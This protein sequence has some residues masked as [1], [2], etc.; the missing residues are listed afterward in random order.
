MKHFI[1]FILFINCLFTQDEK[2]KISILD[3]DG[4]GIKKTSV[5]ASFQSLETSLIESNQFIVIEK[6]K[7]D[8]ILKEQK[9]QTTSGCFTDACAVEVGQLIGADYLVST[10][11]INL[12][13]E[14]Y[15][16]NVKIF[17]IFQG[18][19]SEKV[20]MEVDPKI[21]ALLAGMK[22]ASREIV[23]R[24][25][26]G[27]APVNTYGQQPGAQVPTQAKAYGNLDI[28]T[29][30][31]GADIIIDGVS[32]GNTPELIKKLSAENHTLLL[33]YPNYE[34]LKKIVSIKAD[35]TITVNEILAPKT[36]DIEIYS[37]P[38]GATIEFRGEYHLETPKTIKGI[39]T[40]DYD[41]ILTADDYKKHKQS[42]TIM[43]NETIKMD[44]ELLPLPAK[45][46]I[47]GDKK[48][49]VKVQV[50]GR[51]YN[52]DGFVNIE[53]PA[54]KQ[55]LEFSRKGYRGYSVDLN[56]PPN[57]SEDVEVKLNKFKSK[58]IKRDGDNV[59]PYLVGIGASW[60][61]PAQLNYNL[62]IANTKYNPDGSSRYT[63]NFEYA[64]DFYSF[65]SDSLSESEGVI[66]GKQFAIGVGSPEGSFNYIWGHTEFYG[67]EA[68]PV[69]Y[70]ANNNIYEYKGV[71]LK[72]YMDYFFGE[73]GATWGDEQF[74]GGEAQFY[75]QLGSM[76]NLKF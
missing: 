29:E 26:R 61:L 33:I 21:T 60:G 40:G 22:D 9:D 2:L 1:I 17:D 31:A 30:P 39:I 23:R 7:R 47:I 71:T 28:S 8:E 12:D 65:S 42:I 76:L 4:Q 50:M 16:I 25:S 53:L 24:V 27:A 19:V 64:A 58:K 20:T 51:T 44:I 6:G 49:N 57:G 37:T 3:I 70:G 63:Y 75:F 18:V 13:N 59:K 35:Q 43:H 14:I 15:Q 11:I 45:V 74:Y 68:Y 66:L 52:V 46:T 34:T 32:K 54:G 56:L 67:V 69:L 36:G 48:D 10:T 5:N 62:R 73:I 72:I 38:T 41:L 55:T